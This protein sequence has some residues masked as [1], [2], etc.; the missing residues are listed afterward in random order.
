M[1]DYSRLYSTESEQSVLGALLLDPLAAD[2]LGALRPEHFYTESHRVILAEIMRM[3]AAGKPVDVI[4]VAE[5]LSANG[6]DEQS[7]AWPIS[8]NWPRTLPVAGI[9]ATMPRQSS[10]RRLNGNCSALPRR[11]ER[12]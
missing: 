9:S 4:T 1:I 7:A 6:Q 2:R 10:T 5:E 8:E 12:P 3:I 11:Y